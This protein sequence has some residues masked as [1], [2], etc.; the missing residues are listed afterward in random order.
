M[1]ATTITHTIAEN[2]L[3]AALTPETR[4]RPTAV[5]A[6][7]RRPDEA[8]GCA[9]RWWLAPETIEGDTG[10]RAREFPYYEPVARSPAPFGLAGWPEPVSGSS[11]FRPPTPLAGYDHVDGCLTVPGGLSESRDVGWMRAARAQRGRSAYELDDGGR[12]RQDIVLI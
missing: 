12:D 3:D 1:A 8:M 9:R 5:G 10:A 6:G 7:A 4:S 11:A 2:V